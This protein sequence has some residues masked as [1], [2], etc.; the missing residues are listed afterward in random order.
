MVSL[1]ERLGP[2]RPTTGCSSSTA[3]SWVL[4]RRQ[5]RRLRGP[6]RRHRHQRHVDGARARRR[7]AAPATGA[8]TSASTHAQ[9]RARPVPVGPDHPRPVAARRRRRLPARSPTCGTT[10]TSTRS[11]GS[12]GPRWSGRSCGASTS[13]TSTATWAPCSSGR[14]SSTST[15][16]W[17]STSACRCGSRRRPSAQIGFPFRRL[18]AEEG[19]LFP[20]HF[21]YVAGR[22]QPAGDRAR[23]AD[24]PPGVTEVHVHPAVD[25]R[26]L[27]AQ[28]PDWAG[29]VDDHDLVTTTRPC[30]RCW[31]G[32]RH[33]IGYRELRDCSAP[34]RVEAGAAV[35][36]ARA[37]RST[38]DLAV[39]EAPSGTAAAA[40]RPGRRAATFTAA[41]G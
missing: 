35:I 17:P 8:R 16:T 20:D 31:R 21:V 34:A 41:P 5:R 7:E 37:R 29:R 2:P 6:A 24:L 27:R 14:S 22:R 25:T 9:R 28:T 36:G 33:R 40:A 39:L 3:T 12:C 4:P 32:R 15:S 10:P 26:E 30:A 13:A 18:A 11:A 23:G 19:V 1:A 38:V